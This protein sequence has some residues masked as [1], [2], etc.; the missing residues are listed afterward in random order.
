MK[1]N[2]SPSPA[3]TAAADARKVIEMG[4]NPI[5]VPHGKKMPILLGWPKLRIKKQD[6]PRYFKPRSNVGVILGIAGLAD[7]DLDCMEAIR[8]A[9]ELLPETNFVFG[10]KSR[11][12]AHAFYIASE[13]LRSEKFKDPITKTVVAELRSQKKDG[14][15]GLQTIIP[16]SI[17]PDGEVITYAS[18]GLPSAVSAND[19]LRAF[20]QT[21]ACALL[22]RHWPTEGKNE[23]FLALAGL[24]ATNGVAQGDAVKIARA[25]YLALWSN[26]ANLDQARREVDATYEKFRQG[27]PVTGFPTLKEYLPEEVLHVVRHLGITLPVVPT[28]PN[29]VVNLGRQQYAFTDMGNA[30]RFVDRCGDNVRWSEDL[31]SWLMWDGKRWV[32]DTELQ[33]RG[34]AHQTIQAIEKEGDGKSEAERKELVTHAR[35]SQNRQRIDA[36]LAE[37]KP[38]LSCKPEQ[39]D[40]DSWLFNVQNGTIDLRTGELRPH[41]MRDFITKI[42]PVNF[43]PSAQCPRWKKFLWEILSNDKPM[44]QFVQRAFGYSLT[45]ETSEECVF[46]M[47]GDGRNGKTTAVKTIQQIMGDYAVTADFSTF[48]EREATIRDDVAN[49][50]S[51][52]FVGA[53]EAREGVPLAEGL[54]K[55]LT[56]GDRVRARRLYENSTEFD[57]TFKLW[58]ATNHKPQIKGTDRAIWSRIKLIPF[59]VSFEGREDRGLKKALLE[60]TPGILAWAVRGC[61]RWQKYGLKSPKTV[62]QATEEYRAESD[63]VGRFID[64]CCTVSRTRDSQDVRARELYGQYRCWCEGNGEKS[65]TNTAFGLRLQQRKLTKRKTNKGFIYNGIKLR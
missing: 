4:M 11:P 25:I 26:D 28:V 6:V 37:A 3:S 8:A 18:D 5:P 27:Q 62:V 39:F 9:A 52:R 48:V 34:M 2:S 12:R 13:P 44:I 41:R 56:G 58:F 54:I 20:R 17:H 10:R 65:M 43:D 36:M 33:V 50:R 51:S 29:G 46:V 61:L 55:T 21:A 16:R 30:Q 1:T 47:Y 45:A 64:E 53:Q 49:M 32:R 35:R 7:I 59:R 63:Q 22:A 42:A 40:C 19:L 14:S 31:K 24:L 15:V 23:A 57:P 38:Q 60:E